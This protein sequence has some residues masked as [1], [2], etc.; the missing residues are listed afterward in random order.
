LPDLPNFKEL[1]MPIVEVGS[2]RASSRAGTP[3]AMAARLSTE[4]Q[5][6]FGDPEIANK[7]VELGGEVRADTPEQLAPGSQGDR[8]LGRGCE[9]GTC[10]TD[11]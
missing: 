4:I 3:P 8:R 6:D 11:G 2:S 10:E 1:D 5:E 9:G 7:I